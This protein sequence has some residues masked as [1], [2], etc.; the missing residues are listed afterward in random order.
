M[1]AGVDTS[2]M[3]TI[4]YTN[5]LLTVTLGTLTAHQ[6]FYVLPWSHEQI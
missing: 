1:L 3:F 2:V 6:H 4:I 5:L